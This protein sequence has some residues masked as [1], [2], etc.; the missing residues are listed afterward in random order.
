MAAGSACALLVPDGFCSPSEVKLKLPVQKTDSEK[1]N[2]SERAAQLSFCKIG[3]LRC[4]CTSWGWCVS[5]QQ[6]PGGDPLWGV[7]PVFLG[8]LWES[9]QRAEG[10]CW[11]SSGSGD[12][13]KVDFSTVFIF[14]PK[15]P[16]A[17]FTEDR[18][19]E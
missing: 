8:V 14:T 5:A 12:R 19:L 6:G 3:P 18:I 13:D 7:S 11:T 15:Y 1:A 10:V 2:T 4:Q 17:L 9:A 16:M